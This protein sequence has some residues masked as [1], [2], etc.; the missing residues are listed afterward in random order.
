MT[1]VEEFFD[2]K[3]NSS[4]RSGFKIDDESVTIHSAYFVGV[5]ESQGHEDVISKS[6]FEDNEELR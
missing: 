2:E 1:V 6:R 3:G 4:L 5:I